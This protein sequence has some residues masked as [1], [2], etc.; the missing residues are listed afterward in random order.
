MPKEFES[1]IFRADDE[2]RMESSRLMIDSTSES[3]IFVL[4]FTLTTSPVLRWVQH[5]NPYNFQ[6]HETTY[7]TIPTCPPI[8]TSELKVFGKR[9]PTKASFP[10]RE[11]IHWLDPVDILLCLKFGRMRNEVGSCREQTFPC[12]SV[13]SA[14]WKIAW[15][16]VSSF[17]T[18]I[19]EKVLVMISIG[20]G[21]GCSVHG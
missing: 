12:L 7:P 9:N 10:R 19:K 20:I 14:R 2:S 13:H 15:K 18:C 6:M 8:T 1:P 3:Y 21:T 11:S 4:E 5:W 16:E 17:K